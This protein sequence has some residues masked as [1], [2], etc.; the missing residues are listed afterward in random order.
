MLATFSLTEYSFT[1]DARQF[2]LDALAI[3]PD[4]EILQQGF[5]KAHDNLISLTGIRK[6]EFDSDRI[7]QLREV[8]ILTLTSY[9]NNSIVASFDLSSETSIMAKLSLVTT[10]VVTVL[11][12]VLSMLF[13][14][15]A[16]HIM[17]RPIEKMK[18]TVQKVRQ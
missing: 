10:M 9:T 11:L 8:E 13:S 12:A 15:D 5:I 2:Q 1:P 18:S 4:S 14:R 7:D 16:F 17:I 6:N 3:N